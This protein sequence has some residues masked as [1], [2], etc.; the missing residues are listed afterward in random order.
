MKGLRYIFQITLLQLSIDGD[1]VQTVAVM[2][3]EFCPFIKMSPYSQAILKLNP[4]KTQSKE[5]FK[6]FISRYFKIEK[7]CVCVYHKAQ[8][9]EIGFFPVA[10]R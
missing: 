1:S 3:N 2:E 10:A 9:C 8:R 6:L 5:S 4:R 7:K